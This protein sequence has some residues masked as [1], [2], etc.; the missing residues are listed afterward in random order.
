ME[1][2]L[3]LG[4]ITTALTHPLCVCKGAYVSRGESCHN[5]FLLSLTLTADLGL[6][7]PSGKFDTGNKLSFG[8]LEHAVTVVSGNGWWCEYGP[9]AGYARR[10]FT[11]DKKARH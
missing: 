5:T 11:L 4:V 3:C 7:L 6:Q 2:L 9:V 1:P 8:V 10:A